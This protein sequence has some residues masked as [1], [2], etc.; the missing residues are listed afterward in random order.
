MVN[1]RLHRLTETSQLQQDGLESLSNRLTAV[2]EASYG[3]K[4]IWKITNIGSKIR[5][6]VAGRV[7]VLMSPDIYTSQQGEFISSTFHYVVG[8]HDTA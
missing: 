6:A 8:R 3:G 4:L 2:E 5:D 1:R 7:K